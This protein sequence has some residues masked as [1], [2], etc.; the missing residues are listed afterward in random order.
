MK[1]KFLYCLG[2]LLTC[3]EKFIEKLLGNLR[4]FG[5]IMFDKN[6]TNVTVIIPHKNDSHI[7]YRALDS[8][9]AQSYLPKQILVIDDCS[10]PTHQISLDK[11]ISE[12]KFT[13]PVVWVSSFGRGLAAARNT[14]IF[15]AENELLAFLD[16]DDEWRF[17]KLALQV[18]GFDK[19]YAA[20]HSW[21]T[22]VYSDGSE[23]F[24]RP[25]INYS[26]KDLVKGFYSVTGSSSSIILTKEL[27]QKVGGFD[28]NLQSGEDLDMWVRISA[29][30]VLKC[31]DKPLVKVHRRD[32]GTQ[33]NLGVN[34]EI[35]II[36]YQKMILSWVEK[37]IVNKNLARNILAIRLFFVASEFSR[38]S[39]KFLAIQ[40]LFRFISK[41]CKDYKS[42]FLL[43]CFYAIFIIILAKIRFKSEFIRIR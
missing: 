4:N 7:I 15:L 38:F 21:C 27:A 17:D 33:Q 29:Y 25:R 23:V 11:I 42:K 20:I 1:R 32:T 5:A 14:G 30:G 24:L 19:K 39:N 41:F 18:N 8:I 2:T 28:E 16:C 9:R 43:N 13:L 37:G 31:I 12:Y 10:E 3:Q 22:D 34:P 26:Q 35:K 36:S 6:F 40:F